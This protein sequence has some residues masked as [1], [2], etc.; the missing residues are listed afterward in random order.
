MPLRFDSIIAGLMDT[1]IANA[2]FLPLRLS[3]DGAT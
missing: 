1:D 3:A 2:N